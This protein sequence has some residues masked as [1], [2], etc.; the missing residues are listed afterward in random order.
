MVVSA[1]DVA[2]RLRTQ[3][4]TIEFAQV[5]AVAQ[6]I[7]TLVTELCR[8]TGQVENEVIDQII[9]ILSVLDKEPE[10]WRVILTSLLRNHFGD[11]V[12]TALRGHRWAVDS[13]SEYEAMTF[14]KELWDKI[15]DAS[16][17]VRDKAILMLRKFIRKK[18]SGTLSGDSAAA[19][20]A[21]GVSMED[22]DHEDVTS[23]EGFV[24]SESDDESAEAWS[25]DEPAKA[26]NSDAQRVQVISDDE[27]D[28]DDGHGGA[29]SYAIG[30][31]AS[32]LEA[33]AEGS[34]VDATATATGA[35]ASAL[36]ASAT[37]ASASVS[38]SA[39]GA[40]ASA[41]N[42][43]AEGASASLTASAEG[44]SAKALNVS[45]TG[46]SVS[47]SAKV[48]GPKIE[49]GNVSVTGASASASAEVGPGLSV[50]NV[51]VSGPSVGV[52]ASTT[53][54]AGNV[55]IGAGIGF[56]ANPLNWF[57]N[58]GL[59][60]GGGGGGGG[61][62][63]EGGDGGE[64]GEGGGRDSTRS[65]GSGCPA[66]GEGGSAGGGGGNGG[67]SGVFEKAQSKLE[68]AMPNIH[69]DWA[70]GDRMVN[71]VKVSKNKTGDAVEHHGEEPNGGRFGAGEDGTTAAGDQD[72]GHE[73]MIKDGKKYV[74]QRGDQEGKFDEGHITNY[75]GKPEFEGLYTTPHAETAACYAGDEHFPPRGPGT[76]HHVY[77]DGDVP[78]VAAAQTK[79]PDGKM[80]AGWSAADDKTHDTMRDVRRA[81][82]GAVVGAPQDFGDSDLAAH[83]FIV[84]SKHV[85]DKKIHFREA[86]HKGEVGRFD[87]SW[88]MN[89]GE[90]HPV[91]PDYWASVPGREWNPA[92]H[93]GRVGA[94]L[95]R[96]HAAQMRR[97][98]KNARKEEKKR[99][100]A[101]K[102]AGGGKPAPGG[103]KRH[104]AEHTGEPSKKKR[105][106]SD[107][108]ESEEVKLFKAMLQEAGVDTNPDELR[109]FFDGG[110]NVG[111]E[112]G[113]SDGNGEA[114]E[115]E[116][117][118]GPTELCD[119][120]KPFG[121]PRCM[122]CLLGRGGKKILNHGGNIHGFAP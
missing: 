42:A 7:A 40:S 119:F 78:V 53:L 70:T 9:L 41:L 94:P 84:P 62:G 103:S 120:C 104:A 46:A 81:L 69:Y 82:P 20:E 109:S 79:G 66:G 34:T 52:S 51:S 105:K 92:G 67:L 121:Y 14:S 63:G 61:E 55:S 25:S 88:K 115:E 48:H 60:G 43:S 4:E 86:G 100:K 90:R 24:S 28:D 64:G 39:T 12:A 15:G 8:R 113:G 26:M 1:V 107:E 17:A 11:R 16:A 6:D 18:E 59:G 116:E 93:P 30:V 101:S 58:F 97:A 2:E 29:N 23:Q 75:P 122:K 35:S 37:A 10:S 96:A 112:G 73:E 71:G 50:G 95:D 91:K 21:G 102:A 47:A 5:N 98:A 108:P 54:K 118:S 13:P 22:D 27:E 114:Q 72:A 3:A 99:R 83:E 80:E 74:G 33:H 32:A 44:A 56:D 65:A 110:G 87:I 31:A 85:G 57:T 38:A 19:G 117:D 68:G 45:A 106:T 111:F 36:H 77:V 49:A 89:E 76:I